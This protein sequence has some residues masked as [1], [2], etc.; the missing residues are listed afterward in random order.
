VRSSNPEAG[1]KETEY[2]RQELGETPPVADVLTLAGSC[3]DIHTHP[4][5]KLKTE[6]GK[7]K[8]ASLGSDWH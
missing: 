2:R 5:R 4:N 3:A 1:R 7:L 6:N 8:T